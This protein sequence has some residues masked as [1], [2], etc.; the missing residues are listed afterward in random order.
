[1]MEGPPVVAFDSRVHQRQARQASN[2]PDRQMRE[3][4]PRGN[5][6]T[7]PK[8][9]RNVEVISGLLSSQNP[10]LCI[11]VNITMFDTNKE[12]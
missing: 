10:I 5:G 2:G 7:L 6:N 1:M 8:S 4:S 9:D 12:L 3:K 11:K